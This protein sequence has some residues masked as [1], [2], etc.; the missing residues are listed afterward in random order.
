MRNQTIELLLVGLLTGGALLILTR[1][2]PL[3]ASPE[4]AHNSTSQSPT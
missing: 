4:H 2:E 3:R 1:S